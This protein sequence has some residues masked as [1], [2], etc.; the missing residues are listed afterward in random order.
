[1]QK[2]KVASDTVAHARGGDAD[3]QKDNH[4]GGR[5]QTDWLK[6]VLNIHFHLV[7]GIQECGVVQG[8][9]PEESLVEDLEE[10]DVDEDGE[11]GGKEEAVE[12][13]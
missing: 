10:D 4:R 5:L 3:W 8:G 9:D 12:F 2:L 11:H 6:Q 13:S 1:M 7:D